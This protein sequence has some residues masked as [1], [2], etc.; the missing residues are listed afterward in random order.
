MSISGPQSSAPTSNFGYLT[1]SL[2]SFV[3]GSSSSSH[4]PKVEEPLFSFLYEVR[5][6]V[7]QSEREK[8]G[9]KVDFKL[10]VRSQPLNLVYNPVV[11]QAISDFFKIPEELNR[12][13]Q[14]AAKIRSAAFNR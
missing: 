14:L 13:A 7:A 5:P 12:S 9:G 10:R 1:K 11:F 4:S 2:S 3:S 6:F 8:G